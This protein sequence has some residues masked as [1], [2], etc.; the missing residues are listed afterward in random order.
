MTAS[1]PAA[2][3]TGAAVGQLL[4]GIPCYGGAVTQPFLASLLE[5][6]KLLLERGIPHGFV[7]APGDSLV[8]RSRN[9]IVA[10]FMASPRATHLMFIDSD[11]E[12]QAEDVIRLLAHDRDV[13]CGAYVKKQYPLTFALN[14][15]YRDDG[16]CERDPATG[17]VRVR[18]VATGFLMLK[19]S[20]FARMMQAY[21]QLKYR[22]YETDGVAPEARDFT[23]SLFDC[24]TTPEGFYSE[25]YGFCRR[26]SEIGGECWVDP[27]IALKH[28]GMHAYHAD[29]SLMFVAA[30][31]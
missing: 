19:R 23:Y 10:A 3:T 14:A 30:N 29:P 17:A 26:W 16:M 13:I 31:P 6:Q 25:D 7:F 2:A 15:V 28:H 12:W 18:D 1:G 27:A 22:A 11:I 8:Q 9:K 21:P 5:T 20:V 4:F 24:I